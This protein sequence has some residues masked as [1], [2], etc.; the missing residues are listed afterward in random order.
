MSVEKINPS[1]KPVHRIRNVLRPIPGSRS[2]GDRISI[3]VDVVSEDFGLGDI[4]TPRRAGSPVLSPAYCRRRTRRLQKLSA[5]R[6]GP[7][8]TGGGLVRFGWRG[9]QSWLQ[10]PW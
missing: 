7:I 3:S 1:R 5:V 6:L 8:A 4:L 10:K 2:P 9:R